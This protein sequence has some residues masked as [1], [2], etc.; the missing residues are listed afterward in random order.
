MAEEG[1][2]IIHI[3][4]V[5]DHT[6][7][8]NVRVYVETASSIVDAVAKA[9]DEALAP[10]V[11][12]FQG[13]IIDSAE[14]LSRKGIPTQIIPAIVPHLNI[15]NLNAGGIGMC[16]RDI[17]KDGLC[18]LLPPLSCYL[19][20]SFAALRDGPHRE[21]LN[22]IEMFLAENQGAA[23]K[24]IQMQLQDVCSAIRQVTEQLPEGA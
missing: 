14:D 19:C 17:H 3:A 12:R 16:G 10:L 5:L 24:R 4:E 2:S 1:A 11:R 6:D 15:A 9:T 21:M 7:T 23:D 13:S 18:R 22:S 20:P 8:Q